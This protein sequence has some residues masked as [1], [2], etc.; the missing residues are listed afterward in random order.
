MA[1]PF[2]GT[3]LCGE[4]GDGP[5]AREWARAKRSVTEAVN[6]EDQQ[7]I[8]ELRQRYR[9]RTDLLLLAS[10]YWETADPAS[11]RTDLQQRSMGHACEWETSMI[12]RLS[13][14]RVRSTGGPLAPVFAGG[15]FA[16]AYRGWITR[17]RSTPGHIG[18]P[19]AATIDKGEHLFASFADGVTRLL[20]Q[21]VAWDG[22][23]WDRRE[24]SQV[25]S[26]ER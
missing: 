1:I 20:E 19:E 14:D 15:S 9:D 3:N 6:G 17:D 16:P 4:S 26:P 2:G 7:A 11:T 24:R 25:D 18:E 13:R 8:F 10:T 23:T 22:T 5:R 12:L 21:V